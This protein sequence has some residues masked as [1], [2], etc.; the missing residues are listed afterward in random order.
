MRRTKHCP[1]SSCAVKAAVKGPGV[2]KGIF[3]LLIGAGH[4]LGS[5]LVAHPAIPA[6]GGLAPGALALQRIANARQ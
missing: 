3:S 6:V 1:R 5:A 4:Q 2:P